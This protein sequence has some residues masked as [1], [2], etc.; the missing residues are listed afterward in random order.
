MSIQTA[1]QMNDVALRP[2]SIKKTN[3]YRDIQIYYYQV[4]IIQTLVNHQPQSVLDIRVLH[5]AKVCKAHTPTSIAEEKAQ[6]VQS[7][8]EIFHPIK[9]QLKCFHHLA[10]RNMKNQVERTTPFIMSDNFLRKWVE[11]KYVV[12]W[13]VTIRQEQTQPKQCVI[14]TLTLQICHDIC[15]HA[16]NPG[17]N[18]P[19]WKD[20]TASCQRYTQAFRF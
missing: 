11:P 20:G 6:C 17:F 10:Q 9:V 18:T 16:P 13:M 2:D 19:V 14:I 3:R 15:R 8:L 7:W 5:N 4:P 1:P 12:Q